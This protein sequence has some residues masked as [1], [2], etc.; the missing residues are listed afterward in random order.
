MKIN[1]LNVPLGELGPDDAL[2]PRHWIPPEMPKE[3]LN[4]ALRSCFKIIQVSA[5]QGKNRRESAAYME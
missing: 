3:K 1:R 2:I 5:R 4:M